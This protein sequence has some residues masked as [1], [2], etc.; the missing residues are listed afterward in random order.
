VGAETVLPASLGARIHTAEVL[1][2]VPG[3]TKTFPEGATAVIVAVAWAW[4]GRNDLATC[5]LVARITET[6]PN[7]ACAASA[8]VV[9]ADLGSKGDVATIDAAIAWLAETLPSDA[10]AT[11]RT[12]GS[13][14]NLLLAV[15]TREAR[16]TVA[17]RQMANAVAVTVIRAGLSLG[18]IVTEVPWLAVTLVVLAKATTVTLLERVDFGLW[19]RWLDH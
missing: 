11:V 2:Q 8:A 4:L 9:G 7:L 1:P 13:A 15:A 18:T 5:A 6:F 17:E 14:Q 3:I 19:T 16:R 12:V 10:D